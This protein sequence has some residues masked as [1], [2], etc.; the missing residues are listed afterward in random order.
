M[1]HHREEGFSPYGVKMLPTQ[2]LVRWLVALVLLLGACRDGEEPEERKA[3]ETAATNLEIP[4]LPQLGPLGDLKLDTGGGTWAKGMG[5]GDRE[6]YSVE[7]IQTAKT[8][9]PERAPMEHRMRQGFT[10]VREVTSRDK[11]LTWLRLRIKN[12]SFVPLG[13]DGEPLPIP[14]QMAAFA[15]SLER[16]EVDLAMDDKGR[17]QELNI[18]KASNLP[19]GMEDLFHQLIRDLQ[20][21]LP[22][23]AMTPGDEW[24]DAG[25]LPV[26]R[27]KSQNIL[28]WRL[29]GAYRGMVDWSGTR[30]AVV[31]IQGDLDEQ[32]RVDREKIHGSIEGRGEVKKVALLE[33]ETGRMV[34]LRLVSALARRVTYGKEGR[35]KAR[36]EELTMELSLR[37]GTEKEENK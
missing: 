36:I 35:K 19:R 32:G 30:C 22:P 20:V 26:E 25:E 14:P 28:R 23:D 11:G 27:E 13:P 37:A 4:A 24:D 33:A 1:G 16:V 7:L 18:G 9:I 15:P 5:F 6:E 2:P 34:E 21:T 31:E 29:K 17:V 8:L 10:L 12:P 3:K